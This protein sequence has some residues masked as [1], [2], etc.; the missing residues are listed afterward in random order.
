MIATDPEV[1]KSL[2]IDEI[3]SVQHYTVP[4]ELWFRYLPEYWRAISATTTSLFG[5]TVNCFGCLHTLDHERRCFP[6]PLADIVARDTHLSFGEHGHTPLSITYKHE[7][8]PRPPPRSIHHVRPRRPIRQTQP[9]RR[10]PGRDADLEHGQKF[11]L[12][13]AESVGA[14]Y[15]PVCVIRRVG[16]GGG[17]RRRSTGDLQFMRVRPGLLG[18]VQAKTYGDL[19]DACLCTTNLEILYLNTIRR[20]IEMKCIKL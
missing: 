14:H 8:G 9:T 12:L 3:T 6:T 10:L 13:S 11:P 18:V 15:G 4:R 5:T 2:C 17:G 19:W 16:M 1:G 20:L 7:S